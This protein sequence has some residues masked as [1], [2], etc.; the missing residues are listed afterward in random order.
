MKL[1]ARRI[2]T[3]DNATQT[4][5]VI[6]GIM[7]SHRN[8]VGFARL[9]ARQ[10]PNWAFLLVDIRGHGQSH[11][12]QA[13]NTIQACAED[14]DQLIRRATGA[15]N[16]CHWPLF[17]WQSCYRR[18]RPSQQPPQYTVCV[19][20][21]PPSTGNLNTANDVRH[22]VQAIREMPTPIQSR[23]SVSAYFLSRGFPIEIAAWMTTNLR[24]TDDGTRL[25]L[26]PRRCE[27]R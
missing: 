2:A 3:S 27:T 5:V 4:A 24:S 8:W 23:K 7:G 6:H 20:D 22:V 10:N 1:H 17:R 21:T 12:A 13:P 9:L 26:R 14:L 18:S 15:T 16:G 19:L 11:P 25:A